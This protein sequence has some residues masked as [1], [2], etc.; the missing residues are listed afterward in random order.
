MRFAP[1]LT[2]VVLAGLLAWSFE[3]NRMSAELAAVRLENAEVLRR[4]A[5]DN[6][7][8]VERVTRR[9][10]LLQQQVADID[11]HYTQE[12][13]DEKVKADALRDAVDAGNKRLLILAKRPSSCP[14]VSSTTDGASVGDGVTIELSPVAQRAYFNL[15]SGLT[16]DTNKLLACQAILAAGTQRVD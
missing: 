1:H 10:D 6:A 4:L 5:E 14:T 13:L 8:E 9:A 11:A 3:H 15:R 16:S 7:D 2:A 12:M